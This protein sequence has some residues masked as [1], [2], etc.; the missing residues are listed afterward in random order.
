M[1]WLADE[2][3]S[4]KLDCGGVAGSDAGVSSWVLL[5]RPDR[6]DGRDSVSLVGALEEEALPPLFSPPLG[7]VMAQTTP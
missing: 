1:D 7:H 2:S 3:E 4:D 6:L 5:L